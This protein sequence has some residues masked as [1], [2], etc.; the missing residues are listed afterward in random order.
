[1][2]NLREH[3]LVDVILFGV[4]YVIRPRRVLP[5]PELGMHLWSASLSIGPGTGQ[6]GEA[7]RAFSPVEFG[8]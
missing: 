1:M 7:S 2:G 3:M 6:G 5:F 8:E 4:E